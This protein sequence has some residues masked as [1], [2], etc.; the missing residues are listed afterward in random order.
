MSPEEHASIHGGDKKNRRF[1]AWNKFKPKKVAK[2]LELRSYGLNYSE[3]GRKLKI[4]D[5][6][7]AKYCLKA[8]K[9]QLNACKQ[10]EVKDD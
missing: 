1:P 6:T 10:E 9:N 3:I 4:S 5:Y 8:D 7:V 2:I